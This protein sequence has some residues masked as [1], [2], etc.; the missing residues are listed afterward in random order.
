[1]TAHNIVIEELTSLPLDVPQH[2]DGADDGF[3]GRARQKLS[4]YILCWYWFKIEKN[5]LMKK[6]S[7][8]ANENGKS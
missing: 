4:L 7:D 5:N 3:N 1:M 6:I 8:E 2:P